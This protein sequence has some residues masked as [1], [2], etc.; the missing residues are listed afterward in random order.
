MLAIVLIAVIPDT[1]HA[2]SVIVVTMTVTLLDKV[3]V[4]V[5]VVHGQL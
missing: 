4:V 1:S 2:V 3:P 5:K